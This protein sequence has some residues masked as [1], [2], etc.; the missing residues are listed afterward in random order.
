MDDV[1]Y[2]KYISIWLPSNK[3]YQGLSGLLTFLFQWKPY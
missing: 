2:Y 1:I 3:G